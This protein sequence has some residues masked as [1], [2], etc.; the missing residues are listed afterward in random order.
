MTDNLRQKLAQASPLA[1]TVV[2]GLAGVCAYFSMYAFRKPFSAATF[3]VVPGW[4]FVLDYKIA[5]VI[6]QVAGYAVSK[7]IGIKFV[8]ELDPTKRA[9]AIIVLILAAWA[10]LLLFAVVPAPWN[11]AALFLNGLPLGMIWG[12]WSVSWRAGAPPRSWAR[13]GA[14]ASSSP[15]ARSNP[16]ANS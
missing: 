7:L 6:A 4:R 14:R 13:S 5:L 2:A 10:A 16:W 8:S 12:L 1:L 11:V 3:G 15:R 9:A